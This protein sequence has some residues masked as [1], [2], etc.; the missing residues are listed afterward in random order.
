VEQLSLHD[1]FE[2]SAV[3]TCQGR[4]RRQGIL[5][6]RAI[7]CRAADTDG[8]EVVRSLLG[9]KAPIIMLTGHDT[10]WTAHSLNQRQRLRRSRSVRVLRES[11][12]AAP[13]ET[14]R[15]AVF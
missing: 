15:D 13:A 4:Q 1:E 14:S 3:G 11:G 6:S 9:L 10:D 12:P 2:A 7:G 5:R 8:R